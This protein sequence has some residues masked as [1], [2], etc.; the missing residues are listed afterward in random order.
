MYALHNR[1]L[2]PSAHVPRLRRA[3]EYGP[4]LN[5]RWGDAPSL[6]PPNSLDFGHTPKC[7]QDCLQ[8]VLNAAA[9]LL[10]NRRK[11]DHVAP[12]VLDGLQYTGSKFLFES[13]LRSAYWSTNRFM[14]PRLGFCATIVRRRIRPNPVNDFDRRKSAIFIGVNLSKM[15]V[16]QFPPRNNP[17]PPH[18]P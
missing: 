4:P 9:M 10:C 17:H 14:G 15:G 12:L 8:S 1:E 13:S 18:P 2:S 5:L 6:R 11:Y 3:A 16:G 7:L